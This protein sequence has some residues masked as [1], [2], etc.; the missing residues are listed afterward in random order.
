VWPGQVVIELAGE[1]ADTISAY[2]PSG[3][4]RLPEHVEGLIL[5][6]SMTHGI[7]NAADNA[8]KGNW[9]AQTLDGAAGADTLDG[10]FGNDVLLGGSGDDVLIG[11]YGNDTMQGGEGA[12]LFRLTDVDGEDVILDFVAGEDRVLLPPASISRS[13]AAPWDLLDFADVR[14]ELRDTPDGARLS[15]NGPYGG[16]GILFAGVSAASLLAGD[17]VFG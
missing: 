11:G 10:G 12:D 1:G 4:Y 3:E 16:P 5:G 6:S 15:F 7:G 9:G 2:D 8:I 14:V 13:E 17:F